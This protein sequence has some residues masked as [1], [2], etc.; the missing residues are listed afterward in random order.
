MTTPPPGQALTAETDVRPYWVSWYGRNGIFEL[1]SPWWITGSRDIEDDEGE[2]AADTIFC[3]AVMAR[4]EFGAK[5]AIAQAHDVGRTIG[6]WRFCE[7]R[8]SDWSPFGD[9]FRRADWM[10]W[11]P[12]S[13]ASQSTAPTRCDHDAYEA[14]SAG[15]AARCNDCDAAPTPPEPV[16]SALAD[17]EGLEDAL[18]D[19][20]AKAFAANLYDH[21]HKALTASDENQIDL[22]AWVAAEAAAARIAALNAEVERWIS[23]YKIAH[24]QATQ[25]GQGATQAEA[26]ADRLAKALERIKDLEPRTHHDGYDNGP[27][28]GNYIYRDVVFTDEAFPIIDEALRE[29]KSGGGA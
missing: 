21:P 26:R 16:A 7:E 6:E 13:I 28:G 19:Q 22:F 9:R 12:S 5:N 25:N 20:F 18:R 15:Q 8:P 23:A 24:D 27:G 17:G 3:A 11:P 29:P 2:D 1:H 14:D 10:Q 4:D